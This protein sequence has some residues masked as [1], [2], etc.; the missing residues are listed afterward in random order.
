MSYYERL[1]SKGISNFCWNAIGSSPGLPDY[2]YR[3]RLP[4]TVWVRSLVESFSSPQKLPTM[5]TNRTQKG[6]L[7]K[8]L[9]PTWCI[10]LRLRVQVYAYSSRTRISKQRWNSWFFKIY[11]CVKGVVL[12]VRINQKNSLRL[13]LSSSE[14]VVL[15]NNKV[16]NWALTLESMRTF[17]T[18]FKK[19]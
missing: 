14:S 2:F 4:C 10:V 1:N 9:A 16:Y 18:K 8:K 5:E 6:R 19:V 11:N 3:Y 12:R 17:L 13:D 7:K 15:S